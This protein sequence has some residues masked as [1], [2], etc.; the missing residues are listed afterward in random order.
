MA[1]A[2]PCSH[3][4]VDLANRHL[5]ILSDTLEVGA[6][7]SCFVSGNFAFCVQ[8]ERVLSKPR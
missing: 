3:G 7:I 6:A 4:Y 8:R 1:V 2:P 5:E